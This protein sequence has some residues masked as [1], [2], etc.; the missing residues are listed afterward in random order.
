MAIGVG[1]YNKNTEHLEG[2]DKILC[3]N[4]LEFYGVQV[5]TE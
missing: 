4:V 5:D 3:P 1:K 2:G